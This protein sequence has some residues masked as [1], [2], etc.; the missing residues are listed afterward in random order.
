MNV[1]VCD[2][3][4]AVG[5]GEN[6]VG[7]SCKGLVSGK[8]PGESWKNVINIISGPGH[9]FDGRLHKWEPF[10]GPDGRKY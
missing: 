8:G 7:C 9:T 4:L 10:F 5:G 3:V 6:N 1:D 2:D